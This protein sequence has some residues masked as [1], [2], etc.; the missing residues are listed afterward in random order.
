MNPPAHHEIP[1]RWDESIKA[2]LDGFPHY[3]VDD[4]HQVE[5]LDD[6]L[7]IVIKNG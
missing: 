7:L 4:I 5:V 1:I 3:T 6:G 2:V